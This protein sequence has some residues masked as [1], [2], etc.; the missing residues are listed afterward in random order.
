MSKPSAPRSTLPTRNLSKG[1]ASWN[2]QSDKGA[3]SPGAS[4]LGSSSPQLEVRRWKKVLSER[5]GSLDALIMLAKA[6]VAC[7]DDRAGINTL[8]EAVRYHPRSAAPQIAL[9]W[10]KRC[11]GKLDEAHEH[12]RRAAALEPNHGEVW[13]ELADTLRKLGKI[14][15]ASVCYLRHVAS[16]GNNPDLLAA[17]DALNTGR[18]KEA[19]TLLDAIVA[20]HPNDLAALRM[21]AELSTRLDNVDKSDKILRHC[22]SLCPQFTAA[23]HNLAILL[24]RQMR[25]EE[26]ICEVDLLI[27][28]DG[29]DLAFLNLRAAILSQLGRYDEAIACYSRVLARAPNQAKV[30]MSYGHLLKTVGRTDECVAAYRRSTEL[31]PSLGEAYWSLANLKTFSFSVADRERLEGLVGRLPL[32]DEDRF[33]I[34]FTLGKIFEDLGNY[35]RSFSFYQSANSRRRKTLHYDPAATTRLVDQ[36]IEIMD[37]QMISHGQLHGEQARD[38]IFVIGLPRSGSTLIEQILASHSQVEGTIELPDISHIA[39]NLAKSERGK[40]DVYPKTITELS[41]NDLRSLGC[42]YLRTTSVHRILGRPF[43]VDKYPNNWLHIGLILSI[44]PNARIIDSRRHPMGSGFSCY[45]QHFARGQAF[46]YDLSDIG[47]YYRDYTRLIEHVDRIA[48]GRIHRVEYEALVTDPES[49]VRSLLRYCS[50]PFEEACLS[51]HRNRRAVRTPSAEQVRQPIY[52]SG[53]DHW[54][55]FGE[56]LEPL[57][58]ALGDAIKSD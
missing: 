56:W 26:A 53:I 2:C 42:Q 49:S 35:E 54:K 27:E 44:L 25:S 39:R 58:T 8:K 29:N 47:H 3:A 38:P 45:K 41:P 12:F 36:T 34:E 52:F 5:P 10:I 6:Q 31:A 17:A 43:F 33:H 9:G 51:F 32:T 7:H 19:E 20:E 14:E 1:R 21:L 57:R 40:S 50:L 4:L 11:A 13:R 30:W 55:H 46:S 28:Q 23:R 37:G 18:L 16:G 15:E 22:L 24:H 48:I